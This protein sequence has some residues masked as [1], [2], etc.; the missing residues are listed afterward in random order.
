M[1]QP[2][3]LRRLLVAMVG[4]AS[5]C[6]VILLHPDLQQSAPTPQAQ[7][8]QTS[9]ASQALETLL[10]KGRAPKTGYVR[11]QFGDGW[12]SES[13]C[14]TRNVV[15]NRDLTDVVSNDVCQVVSGT[16][17]DPYTGN[18]IV[19]KRGAGTSSDIQIDHV[20]ALSDAWQKG[21]QQ[22][23]APTRKALAN[24]PLELLA[25]DGSANQQKS[26]GDA[27]TWLPSNKPFRCQYVARQIA[28]KKKYELW[29]TSAEKDAMSKVLTVCPNQAL[30]AR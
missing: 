8:Q 18:T 9:Q 19:F 23:D 11:T 28:V 29:V 20:V 16:L 6:V 3:R 14:D 1:K 26:D 24:D 22:L 7:Q 10:V 5:F 4:I 15:L 17:A 30:P 21:A 13:G 27:A 12:A 2:Y 25:V